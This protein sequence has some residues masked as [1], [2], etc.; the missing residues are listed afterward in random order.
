[1]A[2][3]KLTDE[4]RQKRKLA[5]IARWAK[6]HPEKVRIYNQRWR[7]RNPEVAKLAEEKRK[8][9]DPDRFRE[10]ARAKTRRW[11]ERNRDKVIAARRARYQRGTQRPHLTDG[12][13]AEIQSFYAMGLNFKEIAQRMGRRDQTIARC[14]RE[15][16][17]IRPRPVRSGPGAVG[18][19]GGR[20]AHRGYVYVWVPPDDPMCSMRG[21]AGY[22][23]EHRLTLARKL[24]RQ[25]SVHETVHHINGDPTDNRSENLQ[26]RQGRHGKHV[27]MACLDC[28]SHRIGPVQLKTTSVTKD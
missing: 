28:G 8:A 9:R 14:L 25:L 13:R 4:E 19:K 15:T 22:I 2:R 24:N 17:D 11:Q 1:M 27:A 18:W 20:Y 7:A 12:E 23:A 10:L 3:A 26:L 16:H 21:K 5:G 6:A